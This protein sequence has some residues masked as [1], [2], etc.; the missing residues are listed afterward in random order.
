M[1]S[2]TLVILLVI[3]FH[4]ARP[5]LADEWFDSYAKI[6]WA[7]ETVRLMRLKAFLQ[8]NPDTVA[9]IAYQWTNKHDRKEMLIRAKRARRY[10]IYELKVDR[11]RIF[12][13]DG[14]RSSE[15]LTILQPVRK[16]A[17]PP[18]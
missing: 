12:I 15:V 10:L 1:T 14:K 5:T 11:S 13:A 18:F 7:T 8:A 3:S 6:D 9:Y 16:G 4:C 17:P 2:A